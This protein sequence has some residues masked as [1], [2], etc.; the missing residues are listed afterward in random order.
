MELIV[1]SYHLSLLSPILLTNTQ[2]VVFKAVCSYLESIAASRVPS[3]VMFNSDFL[4]ILASILQ[5]SKKDDSDN[6]I[7]II[8]VFVAF[9]LRSKFCMYDDNDCRGIE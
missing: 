9:S 7:S 4:P 2:P 1:S 3:I 6:V 8:R 5:T